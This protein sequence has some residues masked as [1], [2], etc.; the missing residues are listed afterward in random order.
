MFISW[1]KLGELEKQSRSIILYAS[2]TKQSRYC[3]IATICFCFVL[4][5]GWKCW[6]RRGNSRT[7]T[8]DFIAILPEACPLCSYKFPL[9]CPVERVHGHRSSFFLF[10]LIKLMDWPLFHKTRIQVVMSW[11]SIRLS[12]ETWPFVLV[13]QIPGPVWTHSRS[14]MNAS[15]T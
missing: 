13:I 8:F 5:R 7:Q 9:A 6:K 3:F 10:F 12:Q 14:W 15:L 11:P 4:F 1:V 2:N